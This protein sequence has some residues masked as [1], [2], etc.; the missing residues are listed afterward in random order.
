MRRA[1]VRD[2]AP[3]PGEPKGGV[4]RLVPIAHVFGLWAFAVAQPVLDLIG[5]EP[6][7][8]VAHRLEGALLVAL[9]L[10]LAVVIPAL[11]SAP[12]AF[13]AVRRSSSGRL[14][15]D[16]VRALLLGAFLLQ[17]THRLPAAAALALAVAGSAGAVLCLRRY[18]TFSSLV[19][20][21]AAAAVIAPLVFL[22]RPGVRDLLLAESSA[23]P[24]AW[25]A[26]AP[27]IGSDTPVV[28]V[29]F[30]ELPTTS[31][32]L[33]D[34][35]IDDRRYPSFAAL[36]A[37][38]DWYLRAVTTSSQT[39]K[40]IP[41]LLT[42]RWPRPDANAHYSF[43]PENLLTW[44]GQGGYRV[45]AY[46]AFSN[47]CPPAVCDEPPPASPAARL[48]AVADDLGVV[49]GHLLLPPALRSGLPEVDQTWTG[50]RDRR[51][52]GGNPED[53]NGGP[54]H[55]LRQDVPRVVDRFLSEMEGRENRG[56][57]LYY[58]H[59]NLPHVPFRYLPSGREYVP[60]GA[61]VIPPGLDDPQVGE[62]EWLYIQGVQ[63]HVLQVGYADRVLGRIMGGLRSAGLYD[64]ALVIVTADHGFRAGA[65]RRAPSEADFEE[66]LE[67]PLFVKRPGQ[68]AGRV[69]EHTV[70][71]IDILPT[72]AEALGSEPPWEVDGRLLGDTSE[73]NLVTCC[74]APPAPA[75]LSFRTDPVR[76]QSTLDRLHR[77]FGTDASSPPGEVEAFD[78]VF[79]AGPRPDLLGRRAADYLGVFAPG[80]SSGDVRAVLAAPGSYEDVRPESGFVPSLV[81]GRIEPAV[82]AG[83][84][85]AVAVDGIVRATTETFTHGGAG[86]FS[87]VVHERWLPAG[88]RLLEIYAI[89]DGGGEPGGP[90]RTVLRRLPRAGSPR[91]SGGVDCCGNDEE[92]LDRV[93]E[94]VSGDR[95]PDVPSPAGEQAER[96]GEQG[97]AE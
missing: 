14:W 62:D 95:G 7:F 80:E 78:G 24:G 32:Q 38:A 31:I 84:P 37:G 89:E 34:G 68:Q 42:G 9:A 55:G 8:L 82:A 51:R 3:S 41:T 13:P 33:P 66:L 73:R 60:V 26:G 86:R 11:L 49:Y 93:E 44:L 20:V 2:T 45:V 88:S 53:P 54:D 70:Q 83:T 36:A 77:W 67:V 48:A 27:A 19:S 81:A 12:L 4:G 6:A 35:A 64:R 50:F 28:F 59:L 30:D 56:P 22:L 29:V 94:E 63:R 17:L 91:S 97:D 58:L 74:Y 75:T 71:T 87:A 61:P 40:A 10:G 1:D 47:L 39:D 43:H 52:P 25:V 46:E 57:A 23:E 21:T 16:G 15:R 76:R 5:G 65:L 72:I 90:E 92:Q 79:A 69:V 85:L 18:R 96:D